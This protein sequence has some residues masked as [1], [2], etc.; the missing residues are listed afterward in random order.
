MLEDPAAVRLRLLDEDAGLEVVRHEH[1]VLPDPRHGLLLRAA[2]DGLERLRRESDAADL[3][4]AGPER[5]CGLLVA[6]V[7]LVER[8][9]DR[10]RPARGLERLR[11]LLG[12][13]EVL[14][15][16][17]GVLR[18]PHVRLREPEH[19]HE[20]LGV[21]DRLLRVP[22]A[23]GLQDSVSVRSWRRHRPGLLMHAPT[24]RANAEKL[25]TGRWDGNRLGAEC[26]RV[27]IVPPD[28]QR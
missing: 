11:V 22:R 21:A 1:A 4:D 25:S 15:D 19:G 17:Q 2:E 6:A 9:R 10:L 12:G 28:N 18:G 13:E 24:V 7:A 20:A 27:V 14:R 26:K 8:D 5:L 3:L 23:R 16:F